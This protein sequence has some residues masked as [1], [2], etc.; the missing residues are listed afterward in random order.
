MTPAWLS[1]LLCQEY[2]A[3]LILTDAATSHVNLHRATLADRKLGTENAVDF[4]NK[5]KTAQTETMSK[6]PKSRVKETWGTR[7]KF[8]F[9]LWFQVVF[10]E[11]TS[12][13]EIL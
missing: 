9:H 6:L 4:Q 2:A 12:K 5:T 10:L 11:Y 8:Y 3:I 1:A 7:T 13:A